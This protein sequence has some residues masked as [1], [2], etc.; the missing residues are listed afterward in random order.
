[1]QKSKKVLASTD[2]AIPGCGQ[3]SPGA[4]LSVFVG[5]GFTYDGFTLTPAP[6]LSEIGLLPGNE[7]V[8]VSRLPADTSPRVLRVRSAQ[9]VLAMSGERPIPRRPPCRDG[10]PMNLAFENIMPVSKTRS[11]GER[12]ISA[13]GNGY[14]DDGRLKPD[15]YVVT[16]QPKHTH[17]RVYLG[18]YPTLALAIEERDEALRRWEVRLRYGEFPDS[19]VMPAEEIIRRVICNEKMQELPG[20]LRK[21]R[22]EP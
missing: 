8:A 4:L 20:F 5:S 9:L 15:S 12:F 21:E 11:T 16:V 2:L 6:S 3:G 7:R 13:D 17:Q 19:A 10:N 22:P 1:M 14:D 18:R